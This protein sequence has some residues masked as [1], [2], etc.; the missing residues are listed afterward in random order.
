VRL[1]WFLLAAAGAF[2]AYVYVA[3]IASWSNC[4][5]W[6]ITEGREGPAIYAIWRVVHGVPLYEWPNREPY[7]VTFANYGFYETYGAIARLFHADAE[8][9]LW[10]SRLVTVLGSIAGAALFIS[11]AKLLARP[12]VR[13]EWVALGA[14]GFTVWFGTQFIAWW[15]IAIRPDVCAA[16]FALAGLRVALPAL[17]PPAPVRLAMASLL[18]FAAWSF[19]QSCILSFLG[20]ALSAVLVARNWR[21]VVW[22][23]LPFAALVA[24][25]LGFGG[26]VYRFNIITVPA[27][28]AWHLGAM[29][30]VLARALPQ[31]LWIFGFFPLALL[32]DASRRKGL[33]WSTLPAVARTLG[34]VV[35]V[36]VPLGALAFGRE[37]SNKNHIFEGYIASA[38]AAHLV[39]HRLAWSEELPRSLSF[40]GALAL[41]PLVAFP[42]AQIALPNRLGRTVLCHR[43]DAAELETLANAIRRLPKP[44]YTDDEIF[45]QPWHSTGN[46][47]PA[48]V[49]DPTWYGIAKRERVVSRDFPEKL[50]V[51]PRFRSVVQFKGHPE[52]LH[53]SARGY[54]CHDLPGRPF[55]V[56]YVACVLSSPPN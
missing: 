29:L 7:S 30:E 54:P 10:V 14:L 42:V 51:P 4:W 52:V 32:F 39:L 15:A 34:L 25:S 56:E 18:F 20:C 17:S 2:A 35:L 46:R 38:L 43:S 1:A 44:L 9:L 6:S 36:T 3:R 23:T 8:S 24:M 19:K 47:Y 41:V 26:D 16:V 21:A 55:G 45:S 5:R 31:N 48:V 53:L 27:L 33:A 40:L 37:G 12:R 49:I 11:T 13:L 28:S 22:L 50:F